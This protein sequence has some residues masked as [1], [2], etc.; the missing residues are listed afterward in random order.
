MIFVDPFCLV[1]F[2]TEKCELK[3]RFVSK[4]EVWVALSNLGLLPHLDQAVL[5]TTK[6][7]R[8]RGTTAMLEPFE[9]LDPPEKMWK[10]HGKTQLFGRLFFF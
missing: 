4:V 6:S 9:R 8:G 2:S 1:L 7:S 10:K 5:K 3:T